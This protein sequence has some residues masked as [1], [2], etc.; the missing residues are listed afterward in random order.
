MEKSAKIYIAGHT[1]LV[2]SSLVQRLLSI[3]YYNLILRTRS[4]LNLTN[5]EA[6]KNFFST[7]KPDYVIDCAGKSGGIKANVDHPAEFLYENLQIQ[8]NL[9]WGAKE[10]KVKKFLFI[11]SA[12][13]YPNNCPQPIREEYFMQGEVDHTK[14]GYAH[15]KIAGVKLCES[16]YDEF[17]MNFISCLPTNLYGKG[18]N[19]DP[20]TSHVIPALIRRMHEAKINNMPEIIVWGSGDARREFLYI[21]DLV[22]ALIWLMKNYNEKQFLNIGTGEDI[23]MKELAHLIKG[24]VGYKGKLTFDSTKPEGMSRRLYDVSRLRKAGWHYS[25]NLKKGLSLTYDWYLKNVV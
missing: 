10:N 11:G 8:N 19:F 15:A 7:E 2:G 22:S 23:S 14:S 25:V 5:P 3:G 21:D 9:M 12:V 6:V 17:G 18:D 20:D 13:V 1:G 16:I 4:E 24:L